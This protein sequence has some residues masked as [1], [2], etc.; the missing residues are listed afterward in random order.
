MLTAPLFTIA[1]TWKQCPKCPSTDEWRKKKKVWYIYTMEHYTAIK[2]NEIMPFV[3]TWMDLEIII[4][5]EINQRK[6]NIPYHLYIASKKMIQLNLF[7]KQKQTQ[8]L[9]MEPLVTSEEGSGVGR[10]WEFGS[11]MYTLYLKYITNKDVLQT[12]QRMLLNAVIT[13]IGKAFEKEW[14]YV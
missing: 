10:D 9:R 14:T 2:K 8:S 13:Q 11:N 1:K 6:T 12:A 4:V 5:S 3:A 7:T